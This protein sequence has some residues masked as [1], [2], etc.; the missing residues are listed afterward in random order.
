M[1]LSTPQRP[2]DVDTSKFPEHVRGRDELI[3]AWQL[4]TGF[5]LKDT[6][7]GVILTSGAIMV[8]C[9]PSSES[10]GNSRTRIAFLPVAANNILGV[11]FAAWYR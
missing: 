9:S 3:E 6:A 5:T 7:E 8:R 11:W 2:H 4:A 10:V 1:Q